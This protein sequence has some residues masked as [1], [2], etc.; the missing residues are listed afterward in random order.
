MWAL[1]ILNPKWS[2]FIKPLL[3]SS[4]IRRGRKSQR[5]QKYSVFQT[6][7]GRWTLKLTETVADIQRLH[8]LKLDKGKWAQVPLLTRILIKIDIYS[9]REYSFSP[10]VN[11]RW[12]GRYGKLRSW[13]RWNLWWK[14]VIWKNSNNF[15]NVIKIEWLYS[16]RKIHKHFTVST[17]LS[18]RSVKF[19]KFSDLVFVSSG[20]SH[21]SSAF[22]CSTAIH[23][24]YIASKIA[25]RQECFMAQ[26]WCSNSSL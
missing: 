6:Q 11:F 26:R 20:F 10:S 5:F 16:E 15:K 9:E 24:C 18:V 12:V 19:T 23:L 8:K 1:V 14:Y 3:P 17:P 22:L 13:G 25:K 2:V 4:G 21:S 7:K